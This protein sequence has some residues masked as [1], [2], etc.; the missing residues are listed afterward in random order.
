[1]EIDFP[2]EAFPLLSELFFFF[3]F[4]F[5][6][7]PVSLDCVLFP[8]DSRNL[9]SNAVS[10]K[11]MNASENLSCLYGAQTLVLSHVHFLILRVFS[12]SVD[13][14]KRE[15]L[16]SLFFPSP[17]SISFFPPL[18]LYLTFSKHAMDETPIGKEP[19]L[20]SR[21]ACSP[22]SFLFLRF[23]VSVDAFHTSSHG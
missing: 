8:E 3:F 7:P 13:L 9:S 18:R 12:L 21:P 14:L 20:C 17:N 2:G 19:F 23:L 15:D 16:F 10:N 4:F 22:L 11:I 5:P 1:M 6:S